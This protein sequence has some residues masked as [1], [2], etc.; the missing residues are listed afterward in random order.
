MF[1]FDPA[2]VAANA[3]QASTEDLLDRVT[4]YRA[5]MEEDALA[6]IEEEL[7]NRDVTPEDIDRHAQRR[8]EAIILPDGT[9]ARCSFC[10][11]PAV[12]KR[13]GWHRLWRRLPIFPRQ[14]Y[15]CG[16]HGP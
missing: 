13:W 9:A 16:E 5:G 12:A 14:F 6:I 8:S 7:R 1:S 15:H 11:R 4:V 3:S 10:T 2:R